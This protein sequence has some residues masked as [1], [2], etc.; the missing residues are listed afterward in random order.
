MKEDRHNFNS[1]VKLIVGNLRETRE[2]SVLIYPS[3]LM[4]LSHYIPLPRL[5]RPI[6]FIYFFFTKLEKRLITE[7]VWSVSRIVLERIISKLLSTSMKIYLQ[8]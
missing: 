5:V 8:L 4:A 7:K 6:H 1:R 2:T 3:R